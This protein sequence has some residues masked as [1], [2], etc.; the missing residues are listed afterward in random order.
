MPNCDCEC[1]DDLPPKV[2]GKWKVTQYGVTQEPCQQPN[3]SNGNITKIKYEATLISN[4]R[5]VKSK[6]YQGRLGMLGVWRKLNHGWELHM[7]DSNDD[8]DRFIFTVQEL[9]CHGEV[10]KMDMVNLE[11]GFQPNNSE[12]KPQV[13][14]A[15]WKLKD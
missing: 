2:D 6:G 12:Q 10:L 7:V 8:N 3:I 9:D 1:Q 5:F 15:T 14:Y 13:A 11:S 4:G